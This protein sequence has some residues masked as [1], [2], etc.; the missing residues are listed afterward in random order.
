VY[1]RRVGQ[2]EVAVLPLD[3][4]ELERRHVDVPLV[5]GDLAAL[6]GEHRVVGVD[7]RADGEKRERGLWIVG[8]L[9]ETAFEDDVVR[10]VG[11]EDA[12]GERVMSRARL[13]AAPFTAES[14]VTANWLA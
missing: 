13:S 6:R 3:V 14:P 4:G 7:D 2:R 8:A 11:T 9:G 10:R 1:L 12:R 5:Q